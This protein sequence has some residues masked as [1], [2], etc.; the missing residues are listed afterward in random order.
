[1]ET[2]VTLFVPRAAIASIID[3]VRTIILNWALKLE[4]DGIVG[5]AFS[6][7]RQEQ[8]AAERSPQNITNFYGPVQ[9]AQIQQESPP[10]IQVSL[11]AALDLTAVRSF[12]QAMRETLDSLALDPE[13]RREAEAELSTV[14]SQAE[15]PKP[16]PTI[17]RE[18]L[19]S[20]RRILE[21]AGGGVAAQLLVELGKL[22]M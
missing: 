4:E 2:E 3:T 12:V 14:E 18:G 11:N 15:S 22:I 10:A 20:L 16:K 7:T 13:Y 6:F 9:S 21:N 17:I 1:L 8:D 5:E 19:E